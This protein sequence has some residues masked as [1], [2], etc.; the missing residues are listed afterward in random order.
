MKKW[1]L[2]VPFNSNRK[3][4]GVEELRLRAHVG[5]HRPAQPGAR[6]LSWSVRTGWLEREPRT[7]G[8][9]FFSEGLS[10]CKHFAIVMALLN[11]AF[12]SA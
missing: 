11:L 6:E 12:A 10:K 5:H 4:R 1:H 3:A 9:F 2:G 8:R 7:T